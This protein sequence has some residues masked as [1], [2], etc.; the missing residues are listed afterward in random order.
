MW[1]GYLLAMIPAARP[2]PRNAPPD[3]T[4]RRRRAHRRRR[5]GVDP[6]VFAAHLAHDVEV[7]GLL[8]QAPAGVLAHPPPLPRLGLHLA[9]HDLA[10]VF[11][12]R[13]G[14]T[15]ADLLQDFLNLLGPDKWTRV[16][17]V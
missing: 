2:A 5:R 7:P 4:L 10:L 13:R 9:R 12:N 1:W 15:T 3:Q 8:L 17:V 16:P 6:H 11:C 14:L